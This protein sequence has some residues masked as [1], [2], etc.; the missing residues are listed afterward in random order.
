[1]ASFEGISSFHYHL[2]NPSQLT[3]WL[4]KIRLYAKEI[5]TSS[6]KPSLRWRSENSPRWSTA[7]VSSTWHKKTRKSICR[8]TQFK[9]L[10]AIFP[11]W[12]RYE[13]FAWFIKKLLSTKW[14]YL[15]YFQN[16]I[17]QCLVLY[18]IKKTLNLVKN[19]SSFL[20]Q[21]VAQPDLKTAR[22][23]WNHVHTHVYI[24]FSDKTWHTYLDYLQALHQFCQMS[25]WNKFQFARCSCSTNQR[26]KWAGMGNGIW[27]CLGLVRLSLLSGAEAMVTWIPNEN[28]SLVGSLLS[29]NRI[30]LKCLLY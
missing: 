26:V 12:S 5:I 19:T 17:F 23:H 15:F 30:I 21:G 10:E 6:S 29:Y 11:V 20:N 24:T 18:L 3:A 2:T 28:S 16:I 7:L 25:S 22:N 13:S 8:D 1:M 27:L 9:K 14:N 4:K